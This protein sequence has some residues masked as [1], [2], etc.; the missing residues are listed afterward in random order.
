MVPRT[1]VEAPARFTHRTGAGVVRIEYFPLGPD[2]QRHDGTPKGTVTKHAFKSK[3]FDGTER[4]YFVYVPAQY[5]AD[6]PPACVMVFQDGKSYAD[7]NGDYRAPTVFDNLIH[8][9]EMP[10]T[11]GVFIN[12]VEFPDRNRD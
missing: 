11:G 1:P 10:G 4:E 6:G 5:K 7:E 3:V 8:R 12:P 9:G 2:S